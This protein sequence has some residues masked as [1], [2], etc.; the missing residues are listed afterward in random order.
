[1]LE[2]SVVNKAVEET[3]DCLVDP[4][5]AEQKAEEN[6]QLAKSQYDIHAVARMFTQVYQSGQQDDV[7]QRF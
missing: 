1:M 2:D 4:K 7:L 5:T 6:Y 3:I